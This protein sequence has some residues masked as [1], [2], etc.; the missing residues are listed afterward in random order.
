[1]F[2]ILFGCNEWGSHL[3]QIHF[4]WKI[5]KLYFF[6][7]YILKMTCPRRVDNH[8]NRNPMWWC[9]LT[10]G[11]HSESKSPPCLTLSNLNLPLSSSSTTSR[12]LLPQF[13]TCSGWRWYD[14]VEKWKKIAMYWQTSFIGIFIRWPLF[15]RK[16]GLFRDVKWCLN[17]SRGLKGLTLKILTLMCKKYHCEINPLSAEIFLYKPIKIF[18]YYY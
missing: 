8:F 16:L 5:I 6:C 3:V 4:V 11:K 7:W 9:S 15:V 18:L 10:V 2:L 17:A 14:V 12:E 1:M 13:S